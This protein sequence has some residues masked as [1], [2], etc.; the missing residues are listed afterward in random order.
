MFNKAGSMGFFRRLFGKHEN[1]GKGREERVR[2]TRPPLRSLWLGGYRRIHSWI[3]LR[4]GPMTRHEDP[5]ELHQRLLKLMEEEEDTWGI[6]AI[7]GLEGY[8]ETCAY[9]KMLSR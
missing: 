7:G 4:I 1:V 6:H 3:E 2:K 9:R 8:I 5:Q